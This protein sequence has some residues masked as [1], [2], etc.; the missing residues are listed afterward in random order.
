MRRCSTVQHI[1]G[2]LIK[3]C[4]RLTSNTS[5]IILTRERNQQITF[6]LLK[7]EFSIIFKFKCRWDISLH[8]CYIQWF[9]MDWFKWYTRLEVEIF[10]Q[11]THR[12][13][14]PPSFLSLP[15]W[16]S[17]L[18]SGCLLEGKHLKRRTHNTPSSL[19]QFQWLLSF[20]T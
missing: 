10:S 3:F 7:R 9:L 5:H 18:T 15:E 11:K 16:S 12:A 8:L 2:S 14:S 20:T 6:L 17:V 19:V 13:C 1:K 4:L